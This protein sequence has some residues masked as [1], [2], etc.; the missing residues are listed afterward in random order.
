MEVSKMTASISATGRRVEVNGASLYV[1]EQG[2]GDPILLVQPGL[3]SSAAYQSLAPLLARHYRVVTFDSR[4][5][6]RSTNPGGTMSYEQFTDDAAALADAL[7]LD[8]PFVG[9]W[10]D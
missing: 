10:S 3:V 4:G 2:T 1:E 9:G 8:R 7:E 5:H 6:G